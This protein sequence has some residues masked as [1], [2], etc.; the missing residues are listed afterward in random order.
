K[1]IDARLNCTAVERP[2][3]FFFQNPL[4]PVLGAVG[5]AAEAKPGYFQAG[6]TEI[7][8]IHRFLPAYPLFLRWLPVRLFGTALLFF[9]LGGGMGLVG[10]FGMF[11]R[12]TLHRR[13]CRSMGLH[14]RGMG[15]LH[16]A[17][18]ARRDRSRRDIGCPWRRRGGRASRHRR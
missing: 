13:R 7:Y 5:H 1:E 4:A 12:R 15:A 17:W 6:G 18:L 2:A 11:E 9:V 10:E 14:W 16:L 8:I 3:L